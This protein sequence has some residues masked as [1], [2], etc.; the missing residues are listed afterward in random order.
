MFPQCSRAVASRS[1]EPRLQAESA[2]PDPFHSAEGVGA[3]GR[4]RGRCSGY[5]G[6]GR[7]CQALASVLRPC[8][9]FEHPS[10]FA[11]LLA[12]DALPPGPAISLSG[13]ALM[14]QQ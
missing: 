2:P 1:L 9:M 5:G 6:F 8:W 10:G 12:A 4:G 13:L 3:S 14:T 11:V 7:R